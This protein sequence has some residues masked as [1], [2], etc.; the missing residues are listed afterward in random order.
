MTNIVYVLQKKILNTPL[1]INPGII[2]NNS[3]N[4]YNIKIK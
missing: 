3:N 2:H 1:H 4:Y